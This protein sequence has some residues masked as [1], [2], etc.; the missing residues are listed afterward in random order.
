MNNKVIINISSQQFQLDL[1][2]KRVKKI[3]YLCIKIYIYIYYLCIEPFQV[4]KEKIV[5]LLKSIL[6]CSVCIYC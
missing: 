3:Y 2:T 6:F 5:N 1:M 4:N